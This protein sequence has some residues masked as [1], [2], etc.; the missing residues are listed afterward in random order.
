MLYNNLK[1]L[2]LR[3]MG[4]DGIEPAVLTTNSLDGGKAKCVRFMKKLR[5]T[6][7]KRPRT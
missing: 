1:Q 3:C 2:R 7:W 5:V 4:L 6:H